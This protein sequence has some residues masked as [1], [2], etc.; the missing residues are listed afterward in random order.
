MEHPGI[1]L[2]L[3]PQ[4]SE[5]KEFNRGRCKTDLKVP[6]ANIA[7]CYCNVTVGFSETSAEAMAF[8]EARP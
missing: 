7:A 4:Y 1:S 5:K 8:A 2:Q 6:A 3:R